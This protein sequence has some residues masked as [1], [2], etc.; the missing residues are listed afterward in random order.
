MTTDDPRHEMALELF[1][2]AYVLQMQGDLEMAVD[3]Y[4]RSIE[5]FPTAEAYT[6]LGW[7]YNQQGNAKLFKF[8]VFHSDS[9]A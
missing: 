2:Q 8:F 5:L 1:Q 6:F 7:S 9:A 4:K 3:L